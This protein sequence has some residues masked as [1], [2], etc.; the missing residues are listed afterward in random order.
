MFFVV[1]L[2]DAKQ[3][4]VIPKNWLQN[5]DALWEG[6]VNYGINK[7]IRRTCYYSTQDGAKAANGIPNSNFTPNFDA[8]RGNQFPCTE[9]TFLCRVM[10][11]SCK[12]DP[13]EN[14]FI[15]F[16]NSE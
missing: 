16:E 3:F 2:I 7:N 6:F 11:Y 12:L 4:I 5:V 9:G 14:H 1:F 15:R 10:M 8:P 13:I